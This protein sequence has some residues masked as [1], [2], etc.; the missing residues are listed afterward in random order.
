MLWT[1]W[2]KWERIFTYSH[3]KIFKVYQNASIF[4][5][6]LAFLDHISHDRRAW[7]QY[8]EAKKGA[9]GWS[10]KTPC[11]GLKQKGRTVE[12]RDELHWGTYWDTK[13][14]IIYVNFIIWRLKL[15][16]ETVCLKCLE[17]KYWEILR[18]CH[19]V[20][21]TSVLFQ[22]VWFDMSKSC[23]TRRRSR[24]EICIVHGIEFADHSTFMRFQRI[25]DS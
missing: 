4:P 12:K 23:L 16:V 3:S 21:R 10:L 9:G 17:G 22:R 6:F 2:K 13:N 5:N 11:H 15:Q 8:L 14:Q 18:V 7:D 24:R 19:C 1:F 25:D 20:P